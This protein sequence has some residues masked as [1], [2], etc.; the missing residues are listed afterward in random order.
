MPTGRSH[1]H[2]EPTQADRTR[3]RVVVVASSSGWGFGGSFGAD[4]EVIRFLLYIFDTY[5][6]NVDHK[7]DEQIKIRGNTPLPKKR[8]T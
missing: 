8:I 5:I 7:I 4:I 6:A 3:P 1:G 2:I